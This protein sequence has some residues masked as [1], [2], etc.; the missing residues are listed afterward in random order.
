MIS[1]STY[2]ITRSDVANRPSS[3]SFRMTV[4]TNVFVILAA[5]NL[6]FL[7]GGVSL[8]F[9]SFVPSVNCHTESSLKDI[10]SRTALA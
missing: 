4:A 7:L 1:S 2:S 6:S 3:S 5:I 10:V 9:C 8:L